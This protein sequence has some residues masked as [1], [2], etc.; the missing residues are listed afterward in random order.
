MRRPERMRTVCTKSAA[1]AG[2]NGSAPE[3]GAQGL[4]IMPV[5]GQPGQ[6]EPTR[7]LKEMCEKLGTRGVSR[8]STRT[9]SCLYPRNLDQHGR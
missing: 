9:P 2:R 1:C 3:A 7:I 4:L 8:S 6:P 5:A